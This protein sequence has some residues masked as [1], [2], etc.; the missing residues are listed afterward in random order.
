MGTLLARILQLFMSTRR[1]KAD[2]ALGVLTCTRTDSLTI[3][4]SC[5]Q[6]EPFAAGVMLGSAFAV[7]MPSLL[8]LLRG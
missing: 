3:L 6:T 5:V 1:S 8:G 7:G 4:T 2:T